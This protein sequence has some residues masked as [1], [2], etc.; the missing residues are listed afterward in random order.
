MNRLRRWALALAAV[1]AGAFFVGCLPMGGG[2]KT[3]GDAA[4]KMEK[5][6]YDIVEM[7]SD[8]ALGKEELEGQKSY[9]FAVG[10]DGEIVIFLFETEEYAQRAYDRI[11]ASDNDP[12]NALGIDG[13]WVYYGAVNAVRAFEGKEPIYDSAS[14]GGTSENSEENSSSTG[15][16]DSSSAGAVV[17][18]GEEILDGSVP[19]SLEKAKKKW[20]ANGYYAAIAT[21]ETTPSY[22]EI[23][24]LVGTVIGLKNGNTSTT[25]IAYLFETNAQA[26]AFYEGAEGNGEAADGIKGFEAYGCKGKWVYC[27]EKSGVEIFLGLKGVYPLPELFEETGE[28][29]ADVEEAKARLEA[30][31]GNAT[32]ADV[33]TTPETAEA[34]AGI[35]AQV[36]AVNGA[37]P[38]E[39]RVQA[40]Y[41]ESEAAAQAQFNRLF[42]DLENTVNYPFDVYGI[43]GQWVY[44]GC[45]T[46][47]VKALLNISD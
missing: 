21:P 5:A 3:I 44:F 32:V 19:S 47:G 6:G 42:G 28:A 23:D 16:E 27:G 1:I 29:P 39:D 45:S 13:K 40:F 24:G 8:G 43:S 12:E 35:V 30:E 15:R 38:L 33:T 46:R 41:C 17:P 9:L 37:N 7:N 34:M 10:L 36:I 4:E 26:Q 18:E 31:Y 14:S 20:E 2:M 25:I 22:A 11:K